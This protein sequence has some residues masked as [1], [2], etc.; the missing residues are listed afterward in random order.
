VAGERSRQR[1]V[2]PTAGDPAAGVE[3]AAAADTAVAVDTADP[4]AGSR[5]AYGS[6]GSS[7]AEPTATGPAARS[8][9][10]LRA[11]A[12]ATLGVAV[13][14]LVVSLLLWVEAGRA[15]ERRSATGAAT[16]AARTA[17]ETMLSYSYTTFD[18]HTAEVQKLLTG[19]F[20]AEFAKATETSVKPLAVQNQAVVQAKASELGVMSSSGDTVKVMA[21]V[22]QSTTSA[23][24]DR[25]QVDQNRVI[26]TMTRVNGRWLVSK[27]EAF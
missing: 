24:L 22:N 7:A 27:V 18:A 16:A 23:K 19:S 12:W 13:V 15:D 26:L 20:K 9:A 4:T 21:F 10:R 1:A 5:T 6:G 25:P 11:V 3:T 17:V 14:A 2:V 8:G